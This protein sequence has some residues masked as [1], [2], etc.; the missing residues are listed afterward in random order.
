MSWNDRWNCRARISLPSY[1]FQTGLLGL[2]AQLSMMVYIS[3]VILSASIPIDTNN[4]LSRTYQSSVEAIIS[5]CL[6]AFP[7]CKIS[8]AGGPLVIQVSKLTGECNMAAGRFEIF[9][10][11]GLFSVEFGELVQSMLTLISRLSYQPIRWRSLV[12]RTNAI[13]WWS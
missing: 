3:R 10:W 9:Q 12:K 5:F 11:F 7:C 6:F 1:W 2:T 8:V 4:G 13:S